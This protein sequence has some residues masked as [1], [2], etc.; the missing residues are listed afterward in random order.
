[1]NI[2]I[3]LS[4]MKLVTID[5]FRNNSKQLKGQFQES[6]EEDSSENNDKKRITKKKLNN[7]NILNI[8]DYC[9]NKTCKPVNIGNAEGTNEQ[10]RPGGF[11]QQKL[12]LKKIKKETI[13]ENNNNTN[14]GK[15]NRTEKFLKGEALSLTCK[16]WNGRNQ[17][18]DKES[19]D[20][21]ESEI[22]VI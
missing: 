18:G 20:L 13:E 22:E 12:Q 2:D 21:P 3:C 8:G 9:Q 4:S 5:K 11:W 15:N 6:I 17:T 10:M 7:V 14:K 16:R 19:D 1:M